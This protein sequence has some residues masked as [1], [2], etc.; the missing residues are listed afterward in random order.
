MLGGGMRQAGIL[1]AAG[2]L[3][4]TEQVTQLAVDHTN[5]KKLALGL[6]KLNGFNVNPDFVQ[7]NLVFAKLDQEIDIEAIAAA[8]AK[9]G[10]IIT[11]SNPV[12][13]ATHKDITEQDIERLLLC[14]RALI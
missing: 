5:A 4:L 10:I 7:T 2:K 1:A 13:F 11:P 6:S 8:L 14:L 9:Q 3:A 12:R